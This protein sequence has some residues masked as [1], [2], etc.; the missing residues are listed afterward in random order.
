MRQRTQL[1]SSGSMLSD[2]IGRAEARLNAL[3]LAK[4]FAA[5][6]KLFELP[7]SPFEGEDE[8]LQILQKTHS[9]KELIIGLFAARADWFEAT[10]LE[11]W[12]RALCTK[13]Q[14]SARFAY[15]RSESAT[16]MSFRIC[17]HTELEAGRQFV[18]LMEAP[19]AASTVVPHLLFIPCSLADHAGHRMGRGKGYYD[20]YLT[21]HSETYRVGVIHSHFLKPSFPESWIQ[22]HDQNMNAL[23]TQR[24]FLRPTT[25]ETTL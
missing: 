13:A 6:G 11:N 12:V 9:S 19:E 2:A 18:G 21:Q 20:R 15:P 3:A 24:Q 1:I 25:K 10:H 23:L 16:Q 8:A 14:R 4:D 7:S 5:S 22:P 17:N